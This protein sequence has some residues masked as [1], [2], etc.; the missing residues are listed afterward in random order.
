VPFVDLAAQYRAVK[1]EVD[2]AMRRVMLRCDFVLGDEVTRFE[3]EFA[4]YCG[5][6]HCVGVGNGTDA[7]HLSC[8][9]AGIGAGDEVIVPAFTFVATAL[10]VSLA[11]ARP[12]LV[13]VCP[14]TGLIDAAEVAAAITPRTKAIIPVHIFGQCAPMTPILELAWEHGLIVIE[15]AAQA[16][17]ATHFGHRAGSLGDM[18]CFSFYPSKNLGAYGDGGAVT[19]SSPQFAERLRLLRNWGSIHKYHH[20]HA[21]MNSR[22]DTLQAAVLRAKLAHLDA[23]NERRRRAAT[24]YIERLA[25]RSD[26][27]LPFV[28]EGNEHVYHLFVV[29]CD[30]RDE[31]LA[32]LAEAGVQGGVHYPFAVHHLGAYAWLGQG[33]G[34]YPGAER[35][36]ARCLSLPMFAELTDRQIDRVV[37]AL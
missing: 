22:L 1:D 3:E 35:M 26:L 19:T 21:G 37:E 33:D 13:D 25:D 2:G 30:D 36:A 9:A 6:E 4:A 34:S 29:Q 20:E 23:W 16:H 7:I 17:G 14:E 15:D 32:R 11:G 27:E 24:R 18:A 10:G 28:A 31:R 12:V 8:R 5:A